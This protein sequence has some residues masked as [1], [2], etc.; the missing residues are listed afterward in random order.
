MLLV[1][2]ALRVLHIT[3]HDLEDDPCSTYGCKEGPWNGVKRVEVVTIDDP[4]KQIN[5]EGSDDRLYE[6]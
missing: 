3:R 2:C 5:E 1:Q 4:A 6:R